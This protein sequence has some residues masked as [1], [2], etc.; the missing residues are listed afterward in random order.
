MGTCVYTVINYE[1]GNTERKPL[2]FRCVW[3]FV[4]DIP[5]QSVVATHN[6][7]MTWTQEWKQKTNI[8]SNLRAPVDLRDAKQ[9]IIS[10]ASDCTCSCLQNKS[11]IV[12]DKLSLIFFSVMA[13]QCWL[14]M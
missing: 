10:L 6:D 9:N 4:E 14:T 5:L 1:D 2:T 3:V 8:I 11:N 7:E 13:K 12:S